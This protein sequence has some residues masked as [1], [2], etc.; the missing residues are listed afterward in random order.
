MQIEDMLSDFGINK[1]PAYE[2]VFCC[3]D[4]IIFSDDHYAKCKN[5]HVLL[6]LKVGHWIQT[7]KPCIMKII[8]QWQ[9]S[10]GLPVRA[11]LLPTHSLLCATLLCVY[12]SLLSLWR[13]TYAPMHVA[14]SNS[15]I[16]ILK[17]GSTSKVKVQ[18]ISYSSFTITCEWISLC[19]L[20]T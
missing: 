18:A 19:L 16:Y 20:L 5:S 14:S 11:I 3:N 17:L 8:S 2:I 12:A 10:L 13:M 4:R 15:S 9:R 7:E 1:N 6:L